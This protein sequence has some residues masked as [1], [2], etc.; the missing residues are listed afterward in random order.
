MFRAVEVAEAFRQDYIDAAG[1]RIDFCADV[2]GQRNQ[3]FPVRSVYFEQRR[4][5]HFF[6]WKLNIAYCAE[7]SRRFGRRAW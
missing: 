5:N 3:Q 4:S 6:A 7:Q 2:R 1:D